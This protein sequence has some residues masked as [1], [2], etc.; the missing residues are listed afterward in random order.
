MIALSP[1]REAVCSSS[2]SDPESSKALNEVIGANVI[3]KT[4]P[5]PESDVGPTMMLKDSVQY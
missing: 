3:S 1:N 4:K 2:G 5:D